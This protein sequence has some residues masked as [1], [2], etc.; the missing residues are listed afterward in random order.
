MS[1]EFKEEDRSSQIAS[2]QAYSYCHQEVITQL[3]AIFYVGGRE[4]V[5]VWV[6]EERVEGQGVYE[7]S[8]E[9]LPACI[10]SIER[11]RGVLHIVIL[12]LFTLSC[13]MPNPS[14]HPYF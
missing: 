4:E 3:E 11:S 5:V 8:Q 12:A 1:R 10:L 13:S 9:W 6:F 2:F 14:I 7:L